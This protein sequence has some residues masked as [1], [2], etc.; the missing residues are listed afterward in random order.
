M[1]A[2][3]ALDT[4][5]AQRDKLYVLLGCTCPRV[6]IGLLNALLSTLRRSHLAISSF[7]RSR[8]AVA[9]IALVKH[10][11]TSASYEAGEI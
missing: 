4:W 11:C 5:I 3:R 9:S 10:D 2:G 6:A 8:M 7:M 1:S